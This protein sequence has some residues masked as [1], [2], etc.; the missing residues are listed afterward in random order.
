MGSHLDDLE[1]EAVF[2][3]REVTAERER[4]VLLFS[5]GKDSAILLHLAKKAFSPG[6]IPFPVLH[7]DTGHNFPEVI[8][9]RDELVRSLGVPLVV[10]SVEEAI[11]KGTIAD[12]HG[13][14]AS[15][16]RLQ[17]VPLL[18]AI[19]TNKFDVAFG[20]ARR[21]EDRARAKERVVSVRDA[22][23][24]WD[25]QA[26][27][28]ELFGLLNTAIPQ[29][30]HLR[31]FPISNFTE[32]DVW[33]YVE[34]EGIPLPSLY[35]SHDRDVFE[36]DGMLY[37]V[38]PFTP[39]EPREVPFTARVRFRTVG[40]ATCTGAVRSHANS[41]EDI[42][43]EVRTARTTERGATRADDRATEAA[44]EDRKREGYF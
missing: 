35:F 28:P 29:G 13:P 1:D 14:R 12:V 17:S 8:A 26:Q 20:G 30:G 32:V 43:H 44:M 41:L 25:P 5:G 19:A 21:D 34:R 23:G 18:D 24:Q 6:H 22:F 4:P 10:A 11:R 39:P 42:L 2:V 37:A 40:D 16:N 33:E 31:C 27:R 3:L 7:V 36:R 38:T 9:Y 15:R